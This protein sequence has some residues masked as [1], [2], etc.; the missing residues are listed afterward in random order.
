LER[1][2][3]GF[4]GRAKGVRGE[5]AV[6]ALTWSPERFAEV[7]QVR[8]EHDGREDQ[9][10]EIESWREDQRG[11]L[12]K[13]VGVNSPEQVR[14]QI[15]GGYLT[16]PKAQVAPPPEGR[17]FV[18]DVVGCR[19]RDETGRCLGE[20][21]DVLEMPASD[22]FAVRLESGGEALLPAVRDFVTRVDVIKGEIDVCG[23]EELIASGE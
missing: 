5:V 13:F 9:N 20:V 17:Y 18:F 3:I 1:V 23:V 10:L 22:V 8:L 21:T 16:I 6:E 7:R 2:A 12:V 19:V 15:T 11:L 14:E 4:V